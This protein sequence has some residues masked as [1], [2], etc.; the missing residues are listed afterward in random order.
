V[1]GRDAAAVA[2]RAHVVREPCQLRPP[3]P[4]PPRETTQ[5]QRASRRLG[6]ESLRVEAQRVRRVY[7]GDLCPW[8]RLPLNRR[9]VVG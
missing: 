2:Q 8:V 4:L 1:D 5:R 7:T 3:P 6:R 9:L